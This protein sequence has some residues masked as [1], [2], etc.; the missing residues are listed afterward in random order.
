[1]TEI[2][3]LQTTEGVDWQQMRQRLIED[4]FHNGR[5]P[6]QYRTAFENSYGVVIACAGDDIVGTAR[7]LSDGVCNAYIVDVWTHTDYRRQG[8]ARQMLHLLEE[9]V[10]GQHISLWTDSAQTLYENT[11]YQ[12]SEDTLYEKVVGRWLQSPSASDAP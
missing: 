5:T 8:I 1:M 6:E 11:G 4:A 10:P 9:Q 2:R 12:R 3:Y 7:M